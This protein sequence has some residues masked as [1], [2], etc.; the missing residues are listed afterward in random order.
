MEEVAKSRPIRSI[1]AATI[2]ATMALFAVP[3][4]ADDGRN[5]DYIL[6]N[7]AERVEGR[8]ENR[9]YLRA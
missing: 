8:L 6:D 1:A 2:T 7:R 3:A 9:G 5:Y 4:K